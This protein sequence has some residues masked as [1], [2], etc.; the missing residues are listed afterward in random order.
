[1]TPQP[2]TTATAL[3]ELPRRTALLIAVPLLLVVCVTSIHAPT[4][5]PETH[6]LF[7]Y[8]DGFHRR[9]LFGTALS[10]PFP[11]GLTLV[12]T[13]WI[14][15]LVTLFAAL[16]LTAFVASR[17]LRASG[18]PLLLILFLSS[19]GFAATLGNTGYL[20]LL[21]VI[22]A[23]A[24]MTLPATVAG[25]IGT[26]ILCTVG[27]LVHEIMLPAF[28]PLIAARVWLARADQA[29]PSRTL[30]AA[31]PLLAGGL[32]ALTAI[33]FGTAPAGDFTRLV[34]AVSARAID[35]LPQPEAV[36]TLVDLPT[37]HPDNSQS[38]FGHP[39]HLFE[40]RT[41][42]LLALVL[43]AAMLRLPL[44]ALADRPPVERAFAVLAA[45]APLSIL[46]IAFDVPRFL[47]LALVNLYLLTAIGLKCSP[48]PDLR[49]ALTPVFVILL[50]LAQSQFLLRDFSY[51]Q[52]DFMAGF[53]GVL[54]TWKDW[55]LR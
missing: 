16:S 45:L 19:P 46:A 2:Q 42:G 18:G 26:A 12:A 50:M 11:N 53:P 22:L 1:M 54:L 8:A 33:R 29:T 30:L 6:Y 51:R 23:V 24:A 3:A 28:V 32:T 36:A 4:V 13:H 37:S 7:S 15:L 21:L 38:K 39:A 52:G 41:A 10:V 9:S 27:V 48:R 34:E 40:L 5:W 25:V 31:I 44:T 17:S 43:I 14:A 55:Q 49:P 47:A 20:D 35:F